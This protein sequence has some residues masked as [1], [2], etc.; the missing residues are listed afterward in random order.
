ML[1]QCLK[2]YCDMIW[3]YDCV[4]KTISIHYDSIAEGYENKSYTPEELVN[5]FREKYKLNTTDYMWKN[6]LNGEYLQHF[7]ESGNVSDEFEIQFITNDLK[8]MWY[9]VKVERVVEDKLILSGKNNYNEFKER[10]LY[11]S[12][13][14]SFENIISIDVQSKS[15]IVIHAKRISSRPTRAYNYDSTMKIFVDNYTAEDDKEHFKREMSLDNVI[16]KLESMNEYSVYVNI[17]S[18]SSK[19]NCKKITFSYADDAKNFIT[20]STLNIGEVVSRYEH[21]LRET[22]KEN[23]TDG[24]TDT[25]N[26]NYYELNI[27][28]QNFTGG[29]AVLDVDDFKLCND[30]HGHAAGD[31]ILIS[32]ADAIKAGLSHDDMIIR[33]G[34][35][36]FLILMPDITAETL[37]EKL[38]GI[39]ERIEKRNKNGSG[40]L[41]ISLSIGGV[42]AKN[43][44]AQE[45]VYRADRLM[46]HA[47][48][49]KNSVVTEKSFS[50]RRNKDEDMDINQQILI[51]DD[52]PLNREILKDMISDDFE[53]LEASDGKECMKLLEEY[54]TGISL[55]LLDVIMPNMD[56]FEVLNEMNRLHYIENIPVIIITV[57]GTGENI[58][59]AFG[60][61]A[62]DYICRPYD[63]KV[64]MQR[65]YN[66]VKLYSKQRRL[67]S[68]I[69]RQLSE[70]EDNSRIMLDVLSGILGRKNGE[71]AMHIQHIRKLTELLLERLILKTDKYNLSW[72]D[73]KMISEA[74]I[75]HDIGKIDID[76][77]ILNKPGKLTPEERNEVQK[78][79]LIGEEMIKRGVGMSKK[80]EPMLELAAQ[81]CRSHHERY[82]GNGYPDGLAGE[83]IPI[84]A[85]VVSI[86]DAY[87]ALVSKRSYKEAYSGEKAL[88]MIVSGKCGMFNPLIVECLKDISEKIVEDVYE[89]KQEIQEEEK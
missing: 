79:T 10:S 39:Q 35:D 70:N 33:F 19:K 68:M 67:I 3:E 14:E 80:S 76:S 43:E 87:D 30:T 36:E 62:S 44:I 57:D 31:M 49:R 26:R 13:K 15:C 66:T 28:L 23:F 47:K 69:M 61:G 2:S 5:I 88:E 27:K 41:T 46:Y 78:H 12:I 83:E 40:G 45:A 17:K 60:L 29:V 65:I 59:R 58:R 81:I 50:L 82:D 77:K 25:Y 18:A 6:Y 24:L 32:V 56:G 42:I 52:S 89:E 72:R 84:A 63:A 86:A 20:L 8:L 54:G 9:C 22:R 85:Q 7:F 21:L 53:V 55:V 75:M 4:K 11:E 74:A 64:V 34:G 1:I 51:V 73:C 16:K 37:E 71:S 48:L 38:E